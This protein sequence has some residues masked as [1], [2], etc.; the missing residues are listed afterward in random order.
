MQLELLKFR[1]ISPEDAKEYKDA[2]NETLE[3]IKLYKHGLENGADMSLKNLRNSFIYSEIFSKPKQDYFVLMSGKRLIAYGYA[4]QRPGDI[5]SEL[6]LW[7]R[8]MYQGKGCGTHMLRHLAEY[9]LE[10][11][12]SIGVYFVRDAGNFAMGVLGKKLGFEYDSMF[13]R[14]P[15]C[16]LDRENIENERVSGID[17]HHVL[18]RDQM[19][20]LRLVA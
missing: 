17:I 6:G 20:A 15:T 5:W 9:A 10:N 8:K 7:V 2:L 12:S 14:E 1:R 16:E 19:G 4:V 11:H 18:L 3:D 13:N